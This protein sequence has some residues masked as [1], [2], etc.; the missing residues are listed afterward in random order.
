MTIDNEEDREG[1]RRAGAVVATVLRDM[2]AELRPGITTRELDELGERRLTEL[3]GVSAPRATYNFPGATCI[4]VNESAA[5]G[6]P[7]DYVL[8]DGDM[9]NVDVS[10]RVGAYW[11]DNGGSQVVGVAT[12]EQTR[13]LVATREARDRAIA[14]IRPGV[15]YSLI[16]RIFETVAKQHG[17]S[18][19]RNL[20][21][22][23][24]GRSLHEDPRELY[25]DRKSVV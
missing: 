10:A 22:H 9:V 5:H 1:M 3:G 13:L 4:S 16:G 6:I 17:F 8:R 18:V 23:G 15:Q 19:I 20:C 14:A 24:V 7:G 2:L 21:S 12:D 11:A 25:P